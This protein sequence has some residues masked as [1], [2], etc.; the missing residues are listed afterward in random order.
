MK[1]FILL[2]Y[3]SVFPP[4]SLSHTHTLYLSVS[5]FQQYGIGFLILLYEV[6]SVCSWLAASKHI[7][8]GEVTATGLTPNCCWVARLLPQLFPVVTP[9]SVTPLTL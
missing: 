6:C 9:L 3:S 5:L 4:L 1:H 8:L 7:A 2:F